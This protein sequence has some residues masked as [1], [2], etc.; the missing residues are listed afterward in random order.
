MDAEAET[1]E[2]VARWLHTLYNRANVDPEL[3]KGPWETLSEK[4]KA[5]YRSVAG[6]MLHEPIPELLAALEAGLR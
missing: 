1:V 5:R 4:S 3:W 2:V 6:L